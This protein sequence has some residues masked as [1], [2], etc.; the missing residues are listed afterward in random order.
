MD[1]RSV[2]SSCLSSSISQT[3]NDQLPEATNDSSCAGLRESS[4]GLLI[5]CPMARSLL[6]PT[7]VQRFS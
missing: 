7:E 1:F 5:V 6:S 2:V 3:T 4:S